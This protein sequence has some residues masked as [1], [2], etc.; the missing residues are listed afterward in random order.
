MNKDNFKIE[1]QDCKKMLMFEFKT[2]D[3]DYLS[4]DIKYNENENAFYGRVKIIL[5][6]LI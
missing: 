1:L 3:N 5:K 6:N 2:I 4:I